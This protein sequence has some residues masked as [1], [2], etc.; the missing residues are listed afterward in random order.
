MVEYAMLV[1]GT[2]VRSLAADVS[3]FAADLNWTYIGYAAL[4]LVVLKFGF[5]AFRPT[6]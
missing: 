1:A 6:R 2:A 4:L 5:W 3:N